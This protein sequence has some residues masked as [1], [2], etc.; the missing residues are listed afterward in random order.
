ME[1]LERII[2]R[3]G[4]Y[5]PA[6]VTPIIHQRALS[7]SAMLHYQP[8]ALRCASE[9][10]DRCLDEKHVFRSIYDAN[11]AVEVGL[12]SNGVLKIANE[13]LWTYAMGEEVGDDLRYCERFRHC[14]GDAAEVGQDIRYYQR[15]KHCTALWEAHEEY[16]RVATHVEKSP[17]RYRCA[18]KNCGVFTMRANTLKQCGGS[19]P[20]DVKPSYC[21]TTC[22]REVSHA[23]EDGYFA[24]GT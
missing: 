8:F 4:R 1:L 14:T 16:M 2:N 23:H 12:C 9:E 22:Q 3:D 11:A 24:R 7:L 21:S 18:S 13:V 19:C 6:N 17:N 10:V 20:P 5:Q 15:F